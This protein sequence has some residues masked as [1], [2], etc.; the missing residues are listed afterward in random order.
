MQGSGK[1]LRFRYPSGDFF[2]ELKGVEQDK[3]RRRDSGPHPDGNFS[4][5]STPSLQPHSSF[6]EGDDHWV[7]LSIGR[8]MRRDY[9]DHCGSFLLI[10]VGAKNA[11]F[12]VLGPGCFRAGAW[13]TAGDFFP[14]YLDCFAT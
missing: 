1:G 6:V 3:E 7:L 2:S 13:E 12:Y 5:G 9:V 10:F 11:L 14:S 4:G 8:V